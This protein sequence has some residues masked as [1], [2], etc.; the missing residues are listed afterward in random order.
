MQVSSSL[1][2][3]STL[4]HKVELIILFVE[5]IAAFVTDNHLLF[6]NDTTP[7][8][9]ILTQEGQSCFR[10]KIKLPKMTFNLL[11]NGFGKSIIYLIKG[12]SGKIPIS[13]IHYWG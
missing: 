8:F 4:F 5:M 9:P 13:D 10:R 7:D 6:V 12:H 3:Y 1:G 11:V 2:W